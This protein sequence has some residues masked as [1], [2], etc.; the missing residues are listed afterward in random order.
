MIL[1]CIVEH[2][3]TW[4]STALGII[5]TLC[6][7]VLPIGSG[8][9]RRIMFVDGVYTLLLINAEWFSSLIVTLKFLQWLVRC[10]LLVLFKALK[11]R[12]VAAALLLLMTSEG[13]RL[14]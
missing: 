14:L 8:R 3:C 1:V 2:G 9:N 5:K 4:R 13:V 7:L 10:L 11:R 12:Q 6:D